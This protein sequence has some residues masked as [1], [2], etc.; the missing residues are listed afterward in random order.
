MLDSFDDVVTVAVCYLLQ[1]LPLRLGF[2]SNDGKQ[3]DGTLPVIPI[4]Q[5]E[6]DMY[7]IREHVERK[8]DVMFAIFSM[9]VPILAASKIY[10]GDCRHIGKIDT[11]ALYGRYLAEYISHGSCC[12]YGIWN[13][14]NRGYAVCDGGT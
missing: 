14:A 3:V 10:G 5:I 2:N 11:D 9:G 13:A 7:Y 12:L 6:M 1:T 8:G 4:S